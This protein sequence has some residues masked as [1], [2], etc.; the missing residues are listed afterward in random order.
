PNLIQFEN[1]GRAEGLA[2]DTVYG[3]LADTLGRLWMSGNSG[4]TRYDPEKHAFRTYHVQQGLQGE[5]FDLGAYRLL[6]DGRMAFGGPGGF[7]VFDPPA[8]MDSAAAP[9]V[10]LTRVEVLGQPL[11]SAKPYW[12]LNRLQVTAD[13][14]IMTLEF[15]ALDFTSPTHNR[16]SYRLATLSDRWIELGMD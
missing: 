5:E 14:R 13:A 10:A 7:N 2:G 15:A 6:R 11:S 3:I 8:I 1:L 16:L 9:R 4:L 12:L